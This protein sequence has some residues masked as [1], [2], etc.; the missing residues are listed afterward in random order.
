MT[1]QERYTFRGT[2]RFLVEGE[3]GAGGF[4]I[5]YRAYDRQ[6]NAAVALKILPEV[7]PELL[8]RFKQEFRTIADIAHPNLISLHELI[9][10][11]D[12]WLFTMELVEGTNFLRYVRRHGNLFDLPTEVLID[13]MAVT[14]GTSAP[15]RPPRSPTGDE[16]DFERIRDAFFQLSSGVQALHSAGKLHRDIKPSNIVVTDE[17]RVVLLDFGLAMELLPEVTESQRSSSIEGTPAFM[18]PEQ[19]GGA[20]LTEASD[21]YSVGVMLF[22]ALTGILPLE[23]STGLH[24]LARKIAE[25]SPAPSD[26]VDGIPADLD[27]LCV[28]LLDRDPLRRPTGPQVLAKL[29]GGETISL[30]ER[31]RPRGIFG[32][33]R[34]RLD[35]D[36]ALGQVKQRRR[37]RV[38]FISGKPG[39]G[40]TA[41]MREYL[42][43]L[44]RA[45]PEAIV[46]S[47]R[48]YESESVPFKALD[49]AIDSLTR[50]MR[51]M[52]PEAVAQFLPR[53][54]EDL[55]RLFPVLRGI[56]I[57]AETSGVPLDPQEMRRRAVNAMHDLLHRLSARRTLV[58]SIDDVQWGDVDSALLLS[59]I[60]RSN[61]APPILVLVAFRSTEHSPHRFV[62]TLARGAR[63]AREINVGRLAPEDAREFAAA[64]MGLGVEDP[65]VERVVVESDGSPLFIEELVKHLRGDG[66][67][68]SR[69]RVRLENVLQAR[70]E[71]L[72]EDAKNLAET[73]S[74]AAHPLPGDVAKTVAG[75]ENSF[76]S[77]L[78][79]LRKQ[80]MV[81][82]LGTSDGEIIEMYHDRIRETITA[83][84]PPARIRDTHLRLAL[85]LVANEAAETEL[86]ASH[87]LAASDRDSAYIH[88]RRAAEQA[89]AALA[90][91]RATTLYRTAVELSPAEG[92][93]RQMLRIRLAESLVNSGRGAEAGQA[94]VVAATT[95]TSAD[96][97]ELQ[98]RAAEQFL[99][100]GH[101]DEGIDQIRAVLAHGGRSLARTPRRA[102]LSFLIRRFLVRLRGLHHRTRPAEELPP[103][104]AA[105]IDAC[106]SVATGLAL[107]D[108]FRGADFQAR[109]MLL[110]LRA[111][112]PYR[113]ARALAMEAGYSAT[114]GCSTRSRTTLLLQKARDR[115]E[116]CARPHALGLVEMVEGV[117][118]VLEGRWRDGLD[119][120]GLASVILR[121]RC[122]GV[123]WERSNADIYALLAMAWLGNFGELA[124]RIPLVTQEAAERGDLYA[125][126]YIRSALS[127]VVKLA[128]NDPEEARQDVE[129]A[130]ASWSHAGYHI[131]HY[132]DLLAGSEILLHRGEEVAAWQR[133]M[134]LWPDLKRSMLLR[135]QLVRAEAG[136]LK[137]RTAMAAAMATRSA[138]LWRVA[139]REV[140][141]LSNEDAPWARA[142]GALLDGGL[143][144]IDRRADAA[145][146]LARAETLLRSADMSLHAVVAQRERGLISGDHSVLHRADEWMRGQRIQSPVRFA[147]RLLPTR[148]VARTSR[149]IAIKLQHE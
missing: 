120:C 72:P 122:T 15:V 39:M 22:E 61:D 136:Y 105:D 107:V 55:S 95:A 125:E 121:E 85:T 60:L 90:F 63:G 45:E 69:S 78:N 134:K 50:Q 140:S 101:I 129:R 10:E 114:G 92:T 16:I 51:R 143:A 146:R 108:T 27:R 89:E 139:R 137:A 128:E 4:G 54:A 33:D 133:L 112:E 65:V 64:A 31:S 12:Q 29:R 62:E 23:G 109:H 14:G 70:F 149:P 111:G 34:Q 98:R 5:V 119:R 53:G 9:S 126:I 123:A 46:I 99:R 80:H 106:W 135:V 145:N 118:A 75:V 58:L 43:A 148:Q 73:I 124:Q 100:S 77:A 68:D 141:R 102:L 116:E 142:L 25:A 37:P 35:L 127:W 138:A 26:L 40:K 44:S 21:W 115:A 83:S 7:E 38:V 74:I 1:E 28:G 66:A 47:G 32:R 24:V 113:L 97:L 144:V 48:C 49:S 88:F 19:A 3:L 41:L 130:I 8:Y 131:Q 147:T 91:D 79:V 132:H 94:F 82:V 104:M 52:L 18:S 96:V 11:D 6:R 103:G 20:S 86:I 42:A 56:G 117:S 13:G 81:R 67:G 59:E 36:A 2:S 93:E 84:I 76:F 71:A 87:F 57:R 30:H 17:G 110:A